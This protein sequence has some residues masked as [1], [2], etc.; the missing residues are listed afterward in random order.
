MTAK[1][2]VRNANTENGT[3][4]QTYF[5]FVN[6]DYNGNVDHRSDDQQFMKFTGF[7]GDTEELPQIESQYYVAI[8]EAQEVGD[9]DE[10]LIWCVGLMI[11]GEWVGKV[12]DCR[13]ERSAQR[14]AEKIAK[15]RG[16]T[17]EAL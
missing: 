13:S 3:M 4:S 7:V 6:T 16:L 11:D 8:T 14:L 12:Y 17:I 15:D 5:N 10:T 1:D 2:A 9:D